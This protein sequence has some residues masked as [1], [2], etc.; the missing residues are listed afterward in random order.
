[1]ITV[2]STIGRLGGDPE[3]KT[4]AKNNDYL[5]FELAVEQ[6]YGDAKKTIWYRCIAFDA[7]KDRILRM[8]ASKGSLVHAVGAQEVETFKRKD[9]SEGMALKLTLYDLEYIPGGKKETQ[10]LQTSAAESAPPAT[11]GLERIEVT[12]KEL[13][14]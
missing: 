14:M 2:T 1:M 3:L 5:V 13:P 11:D 6:G 9:G 12:G 4:S 7:V 8:K 10:Q